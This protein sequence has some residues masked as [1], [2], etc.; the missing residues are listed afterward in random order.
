MK[1]PAWGTAVGIWN[2]SREKSLDKKEHTSKVATQKVFILEVTIQRRSRTPETNTALW[3]NS[4]SI[5]KQ[6]RTRTDFAKCCVTREGPS[7]EGHEWQAPSQG[8]F[9]KRWL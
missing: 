4:T 9:A 6:R 3:I 7:W 1:R 2:G 5:K 8:D